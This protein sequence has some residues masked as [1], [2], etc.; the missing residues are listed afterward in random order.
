MNISS[1]RTRIETS[2][3]TVIS[4]YSQSDTPY[5]GILD[6]LKT[7]IQNAYGNPKYPEV[8][9]FTA[10]VTLN[11]YSDDLYQ[12]L[13]ETRTLTGI[14]NS[15]SANFTNPFRNYTIADT[16]TQLVD[17]PLEDVIS[18][19]YLQDYQYLTIDFELRHTDKDS[20]LDTYH[21]SSLPTIKTRIYYKPDITVP[22][23]Y[24][25]LLNDSKEDV[26]DNNKLG[27]IDFRDSYNN[28]SA[29]VYRISNVKYVQMVWRTNVDYAT[30]S[31]S[32]FR[33]IIN[34]LI[35]DV[36]ISDS[37]TVVSVLRINPNT[38]YYLNPG[39]SILGTNNGFDYIKF[40]DKNDTLLESH[41]TWNYISNGYTT[42][43]ENTF[44]IDLKYKVPISGIYLSE[45]SPLDVPLSEFQPKQ[46]ANNTYEYTY[47][48]PINYGNTTKGLVSYT[49]SV[50]PYMEYSSSSKVDAMNPDSP[51]RTIQIVG[52]GTRQ[53]VILNTNLAYL[54]NLSDN[55]D[56]LTSYATSGYNA[57]GGAIPEM[58]IGMYP[59]F[60]TGPVTWLRAVYNQSSKYTDEEYRDCIIDEQKFY[61]DTKIGIAVCVEPGK[62]YFVAGAFKIETYIGAVKESTT[63]NNF[64]YYSG[65]NQTKLTTTLSG[66]RGNPTFVTIPDGNY[67]LYIEYDPTVSY[68]FGIYKNWGT[69]LPSNYPTTKFY[70]MQM[71]ELTGQ[72]VYYEFSNCKLAIWCNSTL[73]TFSNNIYYDTV[74][75]QNKGTIDLNNCTELYLSP[76]YGTYKMYKSADSSN[77]YVLAISKLANTTE[78]LQIPN[79]SVYNTSSSAVSTSYVRYLHD[80]YGDIKYPLTGIKTVVNDKIKVFYIHRINKLIVIM[81]YPTDPDYEQLLYLDLISAQTYEYGDMKIDSPLSSMQS[82]VFNKKYNRGEDEKSHIFIEVDLNILDSNLRYDTP[83]PIDISIGKSVVDD[84]TTF[85]FD[86]HFVI[87][88]IINDICG[89]RAIEDRT[90]YS[91]LED[92]TYTSHMFVDI[93]KNYAALYGMN[94]TWL[95]RN[96]S[97]PFNSENIGD[98]IKLQNFEYWLEYVLFINAKLNSYRVTQSDIW[99][100]YL[101]YKC[102]NPDGSEVEDTFFNDNIRYIIDS[103]ADPNDVPILSDN[104]EYIIYANGGH[105]IDGDAYRDDVSFYDGTPGLT[106][107]NIN[108][109]DYSTTDSGIEDIE[110][111]IVLTSSEELTI[112]FNP[113]SFAITSDATVA[114][115]FIKFYN[116]NMSL[117]YSKSYSNQAINIS[118]LDIPSSIINATDYITIR[119]SATTYTVEWLPRLRYRN[120]FNDL[121]A[122]LKNDV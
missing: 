101:D 106:L 8:E 56:R 77:V 62:T 71:Y 57:G 36:V 34:N 13:T 42:T 43:P 88:A 110:R 109:F 64:L 50:I 117:L 65:S 79:G 2:Y 115:L 3:G 58:A 66:R 93:I 48:Y 68:G 69:N 37:D 96:A 41:T 1:T 6:T 63:A 94:F 108:T 44:R 35:K 73:H 100:P 105:H 87:N 83:Y 46:Y 49:Y 89:Y 19:N 99:L 111:T 67:I 118:T 14:I 70:S 102:I 75:N 40:Y 114:Y 55:T 122:L 80:F 31:I 25:K 103:S 113:E 21:T 95:T 26:T 20:Y 97:Q 27:V 39:S 84:S 23:L 116:K 22:E 82:Y 30:G 59:S 15:N 45:V 54:E 121:I 11:V 32:G 18:Y 10:I 104:Y 51:Y 98:Y 29:D 33:L 52:P 47:N 76:E 119:G 72:D 16:T 17:I 120:L 5:V 60:S 74:T 53:T 38:I 86:T 78:V 90:I 81:D 91:P 107:A 4:G 28:D 112:P 7:Y 61:K 12:N 24:V 92:L 9:S 85:E